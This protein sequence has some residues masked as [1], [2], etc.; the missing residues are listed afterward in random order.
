MEQSWKTEKLELIIHRLR[1]NS[2]VAD[3]EI[4][5]AIDE[6]TTDRG[7]RRAFREI[8][9]A[10]IRGWQ[11]AVEECA[12]AARRSRRLFAEAWD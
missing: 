11:Y 10:R 5:E 1:F 7:K 4:T 9:A 12:R 2:S 3:G 8:N 6:I